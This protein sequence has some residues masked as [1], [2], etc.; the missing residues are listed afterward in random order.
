MQKL[1]T[2]FKLNP[3]YEADG[4]KPSHVNMLAPNTTREYWTWIP[5][6]L[7]YMHPSI[8]RIMSAGQQMA[9]RYIHSTFQEFF[10]DR[11]VYVAEKFG[12][13]MCG[14]LNMEYNA[15]HFIRLHQ[16]GYLPIQ[17]QA[18]HEGIF[19]KA[20]IPH[21]VGINTVDGYAWL[22]LFL[23]TFISKLSWQLPTAATTSNKF[24]SNAV[25]WTL[26]TD[27]D[28]LWL[29]DYMCHDFH[30][31]GGNPF[32]SI[33]VG[34]G[35]AF[36]NRGSDTLNVIEAARYYYDVSEDNVCINSVNA[37]EHSV[38]C[39][40]IFFYDKKLREGKL[41][42]EIE[43]YYSFDLP[44]DGSVEEPDYL[45]IAECLNLRDWLKKFP[46]GILSSVDDTMNFWKK[47]TH[48]Y[49]R[50]KKEIMER[51]GKLVSRPD[52][53]NPVDIIC[54][55][56]SFRKCKTMWGEEIYQ[57]ETPLEFSYSYRNI[58]V[59]ETKGVVELLWDIFGGT[60]NDQGYKVL[61][62]HIGTIYGD[63]INLDKQVQI[64]ERLAAKQFAA[65]NVVLGI[66]SF[67]F[68]YVTRDQAG[69]AAKGAWFEVKEDVLD[70]D[71]QPYT[72]VTG[73]NIYKDP[74]TDKGT[75]KS[76]KGFQFVYQDEDG[77]YHTE[78]EV[79]EAKAFSEENLL[80][81]IYK[82]GQFFN[83]V[84][85]DEVRNRVQQTMENFSVTL[86]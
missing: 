45:A 46:T 48:I 31:R 47:I 39:T 68:V 11:P 81:T 69:Y 16:L 36:S 35:H 78:S 2:T 59:E 51:D 34:L 67:T 49:P 24:K 21:M 60:I 40:G 14:Y 65:T 54:G 8:D 27:P 83:Q 30:S 12:K 10:F 55:I 5:R 38:T 13:D 64:Y 53:G 28:N 42:H 77:E 57:E 50:L 41:N 76:L 26:K 61:D 19:T 25:E 29:T 56:K 75:K 63:A 86:K 79:S 73:Y 7:K 58:K 33:A 1:N 52:S 22:G 71:G 72:E 15:D 3:L 17:I 85:L 6:N 4:Y 37:S 62:P 70:V 74:I 23:E 44:C 80:K 18:L 20:N 32:T 43:W 9:L 66:G 82:D 84:T